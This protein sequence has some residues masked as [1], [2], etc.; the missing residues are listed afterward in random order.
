MSLV[1]VTQS[2]VA[3]GRPLPW[4]IYDHKHALLKA[5][6]E[7]VA[8]EAQLQQLL[9]AGPMRELSLHS[10]SRPETKDRGT[11]AEPEPAQTPGEIFTF[12]DMGLKA[13]DRIQLAPPASLGPER[14]IVK[15]IGYH[16]PASILVTSPSVNGLRVALLKEDL[17]VARVFSGQNAFAFSSVVTRVCKLPFD[18]LHLSF[19]HQIEGA[20]VRKSPRIRIRI[21]ASIVRA[22]TSEAEAAS[23]MI[24]N[25]SYS[26][27]L[28]DARKPLGDKGQKL[29][30]TFRVNLHNMDLLLKTNAVIRAV[31]RDDEP[32]QSA[33]APMVHHGIEF[34][35]LQPNDDMIL[36]SLIYQ[37]MIEQ[38][39]NVI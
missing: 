18:Y 15:L 28:I 31:F 16:E 27:A 2:E 32:G 21:I 37:H 5:Q 33:Q 26:G 20:V 17:V 4:A 29:A 25:I 7:S 14:H 38:P 10:S 30:L 3:L 6:G 19:P 11:S 39:H 22:E 35:D 23:G 8:D 24:V 1:A 34:E 9:D 36:H 13:G 12:H